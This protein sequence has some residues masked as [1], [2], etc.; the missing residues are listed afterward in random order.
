MTITY[1]T[2]WR[3]GRWNIERLVRDV[4]TNPAN[5][6]ALDPDELRVERFFAVQSDREAWIK[7]G[8]AYL[9]V[10]RRGGR[11]NNTTLPDTDQSITDLVALTADADESD[12]LMQY[13]A[14]VMISYE[15][16]GTVHRSVP[17]LSGLS[18]TF[19]TVPGEVVGPQLIPELTRDERFV[20]TTWEI[21][22]ARPHGLPNYRELL[23]LDSE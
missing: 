6:A 18:T 16:G 5:K 11:L 4:F 10:H 14:D 7:D 21:H 19:M 12:T 1:P 20:P 8:N 9:L 22:A 3:G 13:V 2:F 23:E 17:H 15:D